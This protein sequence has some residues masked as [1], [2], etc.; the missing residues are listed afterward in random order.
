MIERT[1]FLHYRTFCS[2]VT[3]C[4]MI[5]AALLAGYLILWVRP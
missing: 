2:A 4:F 5:G 1:F 3:T